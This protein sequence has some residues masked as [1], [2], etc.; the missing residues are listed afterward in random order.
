MHFFRRRYNLKR[1]GRFGIR[2]LRKRSPGLENIFD[3]SS[4][5]ILSNKKNEKGD[6]IYFL[7]AF[8][9][10]DRLTKKL[11]HG[12]SL[13][14]KHFYTWEVSSYIF[15]HIYSRALFVKMKSKICTQPWSGWNLHPLF[16]LIEEWKISRK[17]M[18][19]KKCWQIFG[20]KYLYQPVYFVIEYY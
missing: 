3:I 12:L 5:C 9:L 19:D 11:L 6:K 15:R 17:V 18:E 10:H 14:T 1:T 13:Q 2:R 16:A 20:F 8:S 7:F 4:G